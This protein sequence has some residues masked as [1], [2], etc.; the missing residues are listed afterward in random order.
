ML[1]NARRAARWVTRHSVPVA[2]ASVLVLGAA[3]GGI[4]YSLAGQRAAA[5][6]IS[7]TNVASTTG[8]SA[9]PAAPTKPRAAAG[10][11]VLAEALKRLSTLTGVPVAEVHKELATGSSID[12]IA[13]DKEETV[14][15]EIL[16]R[17]TKLGD[18][19]VKAKKITAAQEKAFLDAAP[20]E[21]E[22]L[23]ADSGADRAKDLRA[24]LQALRAH[25]GQP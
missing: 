9:A 21:L 3:G 10:Q 6:D 11:A 18:R 23:M 5:S 14:E 8:T 25:A 4:G 24:L 20:A 15:Q 1:E 19:A 13:G 16:T 17:L 7:A 2:T 12:T 22:K